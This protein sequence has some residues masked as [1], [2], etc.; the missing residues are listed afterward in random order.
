MTGIFCAVKKMDQKIENQLNLALSLSE[1]ERAQTNDLNTGF[2]ED[3]RTWEL[4]IRYCGDIETAAKSVGA[5]LK[6]LS[7][8]YAIA[9]VKE[10]RIEDFSRL[11]E[12][13][14]IE[15]PKKLFF[16]LDYSVDIS[17]IDSVQRGSRGLSGEGTIVAVI[18][19]GIDYTHPDFIN[20]DGTTR[21]IEIFDEMT[22]KVYDRDV[23]NE[24]LGKSGRQERMELVPVTDVSGHGTHVAGIAAGN[25]RASNGRYRGVA[26]GAELLIVKLGDDEYFSTA[27]LMEAVDYVIRKAAE[28]GKPIAI[29][30]SFGNNYGSHT[31]NSLLETYLNYAAEMW[32]NVISVGSGNE[33]A[34]GVHVSGILSQQTV[35]EELVIGQ[36]EPSLD[37]QLWKS[38]S[39]DF[40]VTLIAPD[41]RRIGPIYNENGILHYFAGDTKIYVYYGESAPYTTSQEIFI[42][43]VADRNGDYI[44]PGIW[45]LELHPMHIRDGRYDMWLPAGNFVSTDTRF[46][47]TV[48]DVTLTIPSTA[49]KVITVGAYD[50][51]LQAYADFSG[52]GYTRNLLTIK[53][54]L[55][56]PG[57]GITAPAPGGGYTA[58]TG[59]SMATPFVTGSAALLMQWGI[60]NGNDAYL[61]GEK[62]KAY[63]IR[64]ARP[65]PGEELP[66]KKIGWGALCLRN[67][68]PV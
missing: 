28:L 46:S 10:E 25:G 32:K 4:I 22:D 52:R 65:L 14:Y 42:Q 64:G 2:D 13:I 60:I 33:A 58:R 30:L 5:S 56:A 9:Y 38:Y 43:I 36:F 26:Y 31:G 54:D 7:G 27:R 67:S 39:D 8:G 68:I 47:R 55:V 62:V 23:I 59:T 12:V 41:G 48:P 49:Y 63:L 66:S 53:P 19:S 40:L 34:K 24:A 44:T 3:T 50:A 1:E 57:V 61:Y 45:R 37:V 6:I 29:N 21:I 18:D 16:E 17:C 20:E 51:R 35:T 15:K 11:M